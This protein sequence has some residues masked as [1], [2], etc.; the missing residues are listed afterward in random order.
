M[1]L[2]SVARGSYQ[3]NIGGGHIGRGFVHKLAKREQDHYSPIR[4]KQACFFMTKYLLQHKDSFKALL[5]TQNLMYPCKTCNAFSVKASAE[6]KN[7]FSFFRSLSSN[8][9]EKVFQSRTNLLLSVL[10]KQFS[11]TNSSQQ[12]VLQN[13]HRSGSQSECSFLSL[14]SLPHH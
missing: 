5:I 9:D 12:S 6:L 2:N 11:K 4:N 3:Q 1:F 14:T 8:I 13:S 7:L 10:K